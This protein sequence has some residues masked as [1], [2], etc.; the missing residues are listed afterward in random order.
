MFIHV[1]RKKERFH[2][3]KMKWDFNEILSLDYFNDAGNGCLFHDS[4]VFGDE[5]FVVSKYARKD[6]CLS[7]IRP[8]TVMNTH[9]WTIENFSSITEDVLNSDYFKVGKVKWYVNF[10]DLSIHRDLN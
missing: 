2:E 9:T 5:V 10:Y 8:P 3:K 6:Q 4:C 1:D 7:M